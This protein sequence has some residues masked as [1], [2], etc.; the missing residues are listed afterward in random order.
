MCR[1]ETGEASLQFT[2]LDGAVCDNYNDIFF[3]CQLYFRNIKSRAPSS[4]WR[5]T[6]VGSRLCP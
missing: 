2:P 5:E 6:V 1:C 3:Q 4:I